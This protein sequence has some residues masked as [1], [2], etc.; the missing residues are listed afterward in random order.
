M[1]Q[2]NV[3][4]V[5]HGLFEVLVQEMDAKDDLGSCFEERMVFAL[6]LVAPMAVVGEVPGELGSFVLSAEVVLALLDCL[7]GV[8]EGHEAG[9]PR[10]VEHGLLKGAL[11]GAQRV[12]GESHDE[13]VVL[14]TVLP[15]ESVS[16]GVVAGIEVTQASAAVLGQLGPEGHH[17]ER[18]AVYKAGAL[19]GT[20]RQLRWVSVGVGTDWARARG[21]YGCT[22]GGGHGVLLACG[23]A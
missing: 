16:V 8:L 10:R 23:G 22:V 17:G 11:H 5:G 18:V 1:L 14:G 20:E 2:E 4:D 12:Y 15:V 9:S 13:V 3:G 7:F 6:G 19:E 21:W